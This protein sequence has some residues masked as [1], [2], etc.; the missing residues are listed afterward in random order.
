MRRE[1][2]LTK[3]FD[4]RWANFGLTDENLAQLQSFMLRNPGVGDMIKGTGGL[5]ET[6]LGFDGKKRKARRNPRFICRI[7]FLR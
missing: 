2:I 3:E 5:V 1:F 6:S 4:V 7:C